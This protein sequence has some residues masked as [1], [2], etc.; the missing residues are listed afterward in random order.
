MIGS[1]ATILSNTFWKRN[2][3][4]SLNSCYTIFLL[5]FRDLEGSLGDGCMSILPPIANN[6]LSQIFFALLPDASSGQNRG[7]KEKLSEI[8]DL[9]RYGVDVNAEI[10]PGLTPLCKSIKEGGSKILIEL[11]IHYGARVELS[12]PGFEWKESDGKI[13]RNQVYALARQRCLGAPEDKESLEILHLIQKQLVQRHL[14]LSCSGLASEEVNILANMGIAIPESSEAFGGNTSVHAAGAH[15][16]GPHTQGTRDYGVDEYGKELA[17]HT[18]VASLPMTSL[19][20]HGMSFKKKIFVFGFDNTMV[21]EDFHKILKSMGV[22]AGHASA[23]LVEFL[24][25]KYGIKNKEILYKVF[26]DILEN[27]DGICIASNSRY[28][29]TIFAA[30]KVLG[31]SEE[32]Q[33]HIFYVSPDL[34]TVEDLTI[35]K[36][37]DILRA[38]LHFGIIDINSVFLI[39]HERTNL[40][41]AKGKLNIPESNLIKVEVGRNPT[42]NHLLHIQAILNKNKAVKDPRLNTLRSVSVVSP[43]ATVVPTASSSASVS[44]VAPAASIANTTSKISAVGITTRFA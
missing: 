12:P 9:L 5:P 26:K 22:A 14:Q 42:P 44:P 7:K 13:I 16:Q 25:I 35:G 33:Q 1:R 39:D 6:N 32:E 19:S 17:N 8:Q 29:E 2:L 40:Q 43:A 30:L 20:M 36:N 10:Q 41:I 4:N 15:A 31:F 38:M 34:N 24:L 21:N 28:P 3:I 37:L 11:L 23:D 27:D 18:N